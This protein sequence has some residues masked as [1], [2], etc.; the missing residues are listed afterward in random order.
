MFIKIMTLL[1]IILLIYLADYDATANHDFDAADNKIVSFIMIIMIMTIADYDA[2]DN[3]DNDDNYHHDHYFA[4]YDAADNKVRGGWDR[5][6]GIAA[7][8]PTHLSPKTSSSSSSS[9]SPS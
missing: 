9:S 1:I 7:S 5:P 4:D 3:Y 8:L 6:P 2:A